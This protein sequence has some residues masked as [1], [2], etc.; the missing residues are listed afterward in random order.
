LARRTSSRFNAAVYRRLCQTKLTK[1]PVSISRFAKNL[2]NADKI[3]VVVGTITNDVR[4]LDV[5]KIQV[6]A[7]KVTET[8]RR[9]IL[10]AGGKIFTFDQLAQLKPTGTFNFLTKRYRMPSFERTQG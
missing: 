9:R 10:A 4:I 2:K 1:A 7:L 8:A 5:P 3:A 6:C